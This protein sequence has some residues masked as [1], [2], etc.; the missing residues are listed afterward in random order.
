[1]TRDEMTKQQRRRETDT[2]S[3]VFCI[4]MHVSK[5]VQPAAML[6]QR[7]ICCLILRTVSTRKCLVKNQCLGAINKWTRKSRG[8]LFI[9]SFYDPLSFSTPAPLRFG[10]ACVLAASQRQEHLHNLI[11]STA[12]NKTLPL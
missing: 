8:V 10:Y 1:M 5:H 9:C 11:I 6:A 12:R 4:H 7:L 2:V 3:A